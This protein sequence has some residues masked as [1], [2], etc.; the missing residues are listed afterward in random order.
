[1][2]RGIYN[3]LE[4]REVF[5]LEFLRQLNIKLKTKYYALK[6]GINLRFFYKSCRYSE[7]MDLDVKQVSVETLKEKVKS[8]LESKNFQD[9]LKV[10][11]IREI[12]PPDITKAKQTLTTQRFK[13][14]LVTYA[15]EDL[16]TKIE[17]SRRGFKGE[18]VVEAVSE[19]ILRKYKLPPLLVPH[20]D[21]FSTVVQKIEAL[22][23][24]NVIQARDIFDL[25]TLSTQF[26]LSLEKKNKID[27]NKLKKA[28]TNIFEIDFKQFRDSVISYLSKEEQEVYNSESL[29]DEIRLRVAKFIE[30][31][32]KLYA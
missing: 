11:G 29:W 12:I 26:S 7:D 23:S 15:G 16:F 32:N 25:Y 28:Y 14:H 4:L 31:L 1:M 17:F 8:I 2:E 9:N 19:I 18:P 10:F 13:V 6:G 3:P 21:I 5:H 22:S 24:R 20:Y 27:S 30:E